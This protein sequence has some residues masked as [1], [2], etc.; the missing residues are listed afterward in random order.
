[1]AFGGIGNQSPATLFQ[2]RLGTSDGVSNILTLGRYQGNKVVVSGLTVPIPSAGLTRNVADNLIDAAGT[3]AG[4]PPAASTLYYVYISNHQATF[5][6]SS[7]RLS[8]QA[9]TL[10]NGVKYLGSTGDALNWRFVGWVFPNATPQ[11][12]STD[13]SRTIVNYY[14][15]FLLKL[16][17]CPG[18]VDDDTATTYACD[19]VTWD[20]ISKGTGTGGSDSR[21]TYIANGED[22]QSFKCAFEYDNVTSRPGLGGIGIDTPTTAK[23]QMILATASATPECASVFY[24]EVGSEQVH[25]AD[26][27]GMRLSGNFINVVADEARNGGTKDPFTTYITGTI[28]G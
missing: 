26:I 13:T 23:A 8:S 25:T 24:D 1:M 4:A 18:Y 21:V 16:F 2:A 3:D 11:F 15:R 20:Q 9:P 22:A 17:T 10:V 27:I 28:F 12:E 6:P 14:N 5:S 7:I 19:N